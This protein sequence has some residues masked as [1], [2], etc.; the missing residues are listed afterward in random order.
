M[1]TNIRTMCTH[2]YT[3]SAYSTRNTVQSATPCT[4]TDKYIIQKIGS[5]YTTDYRADD[6]NDNARRNVPQAILYVLVRSPQTLDCVL[7]YGGKVTIPGS[8]VG[9]FYVLMTTRYYSM[10][11]HK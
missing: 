8:P 2:F 4:Y 5:I 6:T 11:I 9:A 1:R 10:H 7:S 3:H